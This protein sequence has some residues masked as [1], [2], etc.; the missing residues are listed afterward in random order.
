MGLA[1]FGGSFELGIDEKGEI[2]IW[3]QG[4]RD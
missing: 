2:R 3:A 4:C 1:Q